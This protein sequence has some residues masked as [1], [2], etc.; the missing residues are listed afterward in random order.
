MVSSI[1]IK[2]EIIMDKFL[3]K[4]IWLII[5]AP[6]IYLAIVWNKLPQ[7]IAIHFNLRGNPDRYGSKTGLIVGVAVLMV[8]AT[9]IWLLMPLVYKIDRKKRA[10]ENKPRLLRMAFAISLFIS[11]VSCILINSSVYSIHF[12][13]RLIFGSIGLMWC[14]MGNYMHNI[15]PNHFAGFRTSWTLNNEE[16][17]RKTHLLGGKLWFTGGLLVTIVCFFASINIVVITFVSVSLI[18]ILIP[19]IYSYRLYKKQ[20]ALNSIS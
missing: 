20:K 3:K 15:K 18:I 11:F 17:W 14:I 7:K 5:I 8:L 10:V 19:F 16:N 13:I 2:K 9:A 4:I 6:A 1:Q 12:N